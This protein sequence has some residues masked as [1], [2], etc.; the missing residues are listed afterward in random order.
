MTE[1]MAH[2]LVT[3]ML[4]EV[5]LQRIDPNALDRLGVELLR[6]ELAAALSVSEILPVGGFVAGAGEARLLDEG[7]PQYGAIGVA[8]VPLLGRASGDQGE[9]AKRGFYS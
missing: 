5:T 1:C 4:A 8:G 7:F 2:L 9:H 6:V 3:Q